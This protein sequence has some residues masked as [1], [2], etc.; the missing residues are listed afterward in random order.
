MSKFKE[1]EEIM[2]NEEINGNNSKKR[3]RGK[4][5]L[6]TVIIPLA[7][8][9]ALFFALIMYQQNQMKAYNTKEVVVAITEV[10]EKLAVSKQNAATYFQTIRVPENAVVDGT[11][12]S[13]NDLVGL[14]TADDIHAHEIV[15]KY[16]MT[17]E[18]DYI[19][20]VQDPVEISFA[21][22]DAADAVGGTIRAGDIVDVSVLSDSTKKL[23][24]V[25]EDVYIKQ[26]YDSSN[27]VVSE[28]D[29]ASAVVFVCVVDKSE[30]TNLI[31]KLSEG[32]VHVTLPE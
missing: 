14:I 6:G 31:E 30:R 3:K 8:S 22:N 10:P 2:K 1:N 9:L 12:T 25:L 32:E 13:V 20:T 18:N 27:N 4:G 15:S 11:Y 28:G 19:S 16:S 5:G 7:I 24:S 23:E 21:V 26:V 29:T 17:D